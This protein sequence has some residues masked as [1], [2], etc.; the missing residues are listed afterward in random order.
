MADRIIS[1]RPAVAVCGG[2]VIELEIAGAALASATGA[3]LEAGVSCLDASSQP[4]PGAVNARPLLGSSVAA[5][6]ADRAIGQ[7]NARGKQC[8]PLRQ[9]PKS[10]GG[11]CPL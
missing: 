2:V 4:W 11:A 9:L 10:G 8:V 7:H 6:A 1:L 5:C 3:G